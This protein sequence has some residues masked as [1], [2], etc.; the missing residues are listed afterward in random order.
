MLRLVKLS[1]E[2]MDL[3][4]LL[5]VALIVFLTECHNFW[6]NSKTTPSRELCTESNVK[7]LSL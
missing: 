2:P 3:V 6:R 4:T 7:L 1:F 5:V